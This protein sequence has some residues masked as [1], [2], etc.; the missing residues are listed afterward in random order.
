MTQN[1]ANRINF[2]VTVAFS[3]NPDMF[4][5][6]FHVLQVFPLHFDMK[7]EIFL[8]DLEVFQNYITRLR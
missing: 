4:I 5:D 7:D 2:K 6:N 1:L 8:S 3:S